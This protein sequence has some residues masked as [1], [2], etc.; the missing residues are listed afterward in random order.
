MILMG[1]SNDPVIRVLDDVDGIGGKSGERPLAKDLCFARLITRF[2][3]FR[4]SKELD[5]VSSLLKK[6]IL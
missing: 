2:G 3:Y 1:N 5:R 4:E 6:I